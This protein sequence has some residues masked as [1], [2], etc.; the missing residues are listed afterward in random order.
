MSDID[1]HD[2]FMLLGQRTSGTPDHLLESVKP[3]TLRLD[4]KFVCKVDA[5]A[6]SVGLTRQALLTELVVSAFKEAESGFLSGCSSELAQ[7]YDYRCEM[8]IREVEGE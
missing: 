3:V 8:C 2:R 1:I 5:L 6:A 4:S 7:E